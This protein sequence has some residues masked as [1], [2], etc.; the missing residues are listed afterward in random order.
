LDNID[1]NGNHL[2]VE[3]DESYYF[4]RKYH[5]G[6]FRRGK[7]VVG[8]GE[9][10]TGRCWLEIV[11]RRNA[12]TL[13]RIIADHVLPGSIVVTDAWGGYANVGQMNNGVYQHEVVVHAQHFVDEHH[14]EINT[15]A[16]EGLWMH[17]KRKLRYQSGT[18]L[19]CSP[20]IWMSS[21]C[22]L[23]KRNMFLEHI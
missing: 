22:V 4:H 21:R 20:V 19:S 15:E 3:V 7:W 2:Y 13:E 18:S 16:I 6:V 10:Q 23:V 14:P 8:I 5:R 12:R 11:A 9:R 1:A 17:A